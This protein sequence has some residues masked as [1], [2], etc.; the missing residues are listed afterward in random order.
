M[1]SIDRNIKS[2][3]GKVDIVGHGDEHNQ[4]VNNFQ[5]DSREERFDGKPVLKW[6]GSD[7]H[8]STQPTNQD[9][10]LTNSTPL[11]V[12]CT[13]FKFS[14]RAASDH[15]FESREEI[16]VNFKIVHSPSMKILSSV[17][18]EQASVIK[19]D[20]NLNNSSDNICQPKF[21]SRSAHPSMMQLIPLT[22]GIHLTQLQTSMREC[23]PISL[24][25]L[26]LSPELRPNKHTRCKKFS[27]RMRNHHFEAISQ[28]DSMNVS[29][30]VIVIDKSKKQLEEDRNLCDNHEIAPL[31]QKN[32]ERLA[33]VRCARPKS[34]KSSHLEENVENGDL[35]EEME[36]PC[37]SYEDE[38][39]E[40]MDHSIPE[41]FDE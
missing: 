23:K 28:S 13:N 38:G 17:S 12:E 31:E 5:I 16:A 33:I 27:Q 1:K 35:D 2:D 34:L 11:Q 21:R 7:I 14:P 15:Y 20:A 32:I 3:E 9:A 29:N 8:C 30:K 36:I 26:L 40:E 25:S 39:C 10:C 41:S 18:G 24:C 6:K 37:S 4:H 22:N 19:L